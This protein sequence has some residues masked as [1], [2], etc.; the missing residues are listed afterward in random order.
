MVNQLTDYNRFQSLFFLPKKIQYLQRDL[1]F[2]LTY[3]TIED[4]AIN[5]NYFY[6]LFFLFLFSTY[7]STPLVFNLV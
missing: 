7:Y 1:N 6:D 5:G 3:K 4:D 2:F